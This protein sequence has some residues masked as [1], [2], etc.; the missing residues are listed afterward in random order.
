MA[1][2]FPRDGDVRERDSVKPLVESGTEFPI[3]RAD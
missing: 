2:R 3:K 1:V